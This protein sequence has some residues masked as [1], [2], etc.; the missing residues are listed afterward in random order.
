M[1]EIKPQALKS[2]VLWGHFHPTCS[3]GPIPTIWDVLGHSR[4]RSGH[5]FPGPPPGVPCAPA[6]SASAWTPLVH[7]AGADVELDHVAVRSGGPHS[8]TAKS[9]QTL[10]CLPVSCEGGSVGLTGPPQRLPIPTTSILA[11]YLAGWPLLSCSLPWI[12]LVLLPAMPP[13]PSFLPADPPPPSS[14]R[15][16]PAHP[17]TPPFPLSAGQRGPSIPAAPPDREPL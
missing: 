15:N 4:T 16:V 3:L 5:A 17:W 10:V 11:R 14:L 2:V 9:H 8:V 13:Q 1:D 7:S 12:I 6:S